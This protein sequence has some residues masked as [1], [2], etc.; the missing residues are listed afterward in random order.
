VIAFLR[1][2]NE[3]NNEINEWIQECIDPDRTT[4]N[5]IPAGEQWVKNKMMD[6]G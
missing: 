6:L 3:T 2:I 1:G 4:I 5:A